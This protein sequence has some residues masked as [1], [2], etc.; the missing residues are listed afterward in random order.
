[1]PRKRRELPEPGESAEQ[2]EAYLRALWEQL[3]SFSP[4]GLDDNFFEL[5]GHSLLAA[6]MLAE[7]QARD[8]TRIAARDTHHRADHRAAR[9]GDRG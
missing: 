7:V 5:G 1:M 3:F 9:G 6:Q 2:I 4:I 8:R